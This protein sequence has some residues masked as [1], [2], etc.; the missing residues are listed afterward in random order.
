[1]VEAERTGGPMVEA[2]RTRVCGKPRLTSESQIKSMRVETS[3]D[4]LTQV[5]LCE[6]AS[7]A[8]ES[9]A[10]RLKHC[11][12]PGWPPHWPWRGLC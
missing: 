8:L 4:Q 3:E 1:M 10:P 7:P 9:P 12:N 5:S 2:E 11:G 6:F